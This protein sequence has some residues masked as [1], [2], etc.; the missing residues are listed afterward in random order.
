MRLQNPILAM[1]LLATAWVAQAANA[2][3]T[4]IQTWLR[5]SAKLQRTDQAKSLKL[6]E[7]ALMQSQ[8]LQ[9]TRGI[10]SAGIRIGSI[11]YTNGA[12][13]TSKQVIQ[14]SLNLF[15]SANDPKGAAGAELLLSYIYLDLGMKDSAFA[16]LYAAL[17]HN[18]KTSDSVG[19]AQIYINLGNLHLDYGDLKLAKEN[20]MA[21]AKISE[22]AG[23]FDGSISAWDGLGRYFLEVKEYRTALEYFY[24][25]A[26][27]SRNIK[28]VYSV[29]QNLTNIALCF[30]LL[31][32]YPKAKDKY[33][34]ALAAC[35]NLKMVAGIALGHY[36]LGNMFLLLKKTD[37]AI[38]HLKLAVRYG[39]SADDPVRV[40]RSYKLLGTA[41][42][43]LGNFQQAFGYEQAYTELNDSILNTEKVKQIAEMQTRYDTEKKV[44]QIKVLNAEA[45][46]K[47][48][49]RNIFIVG[50]VLFLLL[51]IA[52]GVGLVKTR[53]EKRIS[54]TLLLNILPSE[55]ADELKLKGSADAQFFDEVTVLFT[56]FKDFTQITE[57]MSPAE[58]VDLLH[59]CFKTFDNIITKHRVEK[60]K[61][62]GDSYM[63]AGGLPVPHK[64][65]AADVVRAALEIQKFIEKLTA[66]RIREGKEPIVMRLGIH[67]GPVVAGIVGVKKFAYDIWGDTVNTASRMESSGEPGKVNISGD[68][69]ELIKDEFKCVARG[70][71]QAKHKGEIEMYFVES[72]I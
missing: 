62:I 34:E 38:I 69:Y 56:D 41:Y 40:A 27:A 1:L 8:K 19:L 60:I 35:Q 16:S 10:A 48:A 33:N 65:E 7:Q 24:K 28:D 4:T 67:T 44:Q 47:I 22:N 6:A 66:D 43:D 15:E 55:V 68:T 63:C 42:S 5:E 18:K 72:E 61:T 52:V 9:Y 50:M 26:G 31:E 58:L 46:A 30:E 3:T 25:V 32:E 53:K 17:K 21:A 57:K 20:F 13:D 54:E 11:L 45:R 51:A 49:Q 2:D 14:H 39:R 71:I 36:N 37:S 12:V 29:A 70:K 23:D 59:Y 64:S